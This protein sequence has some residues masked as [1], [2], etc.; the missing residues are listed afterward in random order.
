ML[1]GNAMNLS[2]NCALVTSM[3]F[4]A[5][6]I[7]GCGS[8]A[9]DPSAS[10][11][12]PVAAVA[13]KVDF[14]SLVVTKLK[15]NPGDSNQP[16]TK[17]CYAVFAGPAGFPNDGT[18]V[19]ASG[20]KAIDSTIVSFLLEDLP[21]TNDGYAISLFQDMNGNEKLDTRGLLGLRIPDEPFG[22]TNNP[23]ALRAP[24]Y[25]EVRINPVKNGDKFTI[26]MRSL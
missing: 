2:R 5:S 12:A 11:D 24:T 22:F 17:I 14:I 21:A 4:A 26:N 8:N 19:V 15:F 23:T 16:P 13:A 25:T 1:K 10:L 7:T 20:C 18:K 3:F 9:A 6:A